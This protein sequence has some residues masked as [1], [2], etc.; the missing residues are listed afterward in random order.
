[1]NKP[2]LDFSSR[3]YSFDVYAYESRFDLAVIH[4][5]SD[6]V[7]KPFKVV[8]GFMFKFD[9]EYHTMLGFATIEEAYAIYDAILVAMKGNQS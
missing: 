1:M 9:Y 7:E 8:Q 2:A 5:I 3:Q 6:D 4:N